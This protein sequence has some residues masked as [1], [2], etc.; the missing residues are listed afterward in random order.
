MS[1][2]SMKDLE[3]NYTHLCNNSIQKEGDNFEQIKNSSMWDLQSFKSFLSSHD[4]QA[5]WEDKILPQMK[6]I[7]KWALMCAQD[8]LE[9]RKFSCEVY[10]YDF[11]LD[12]D[13]NVWL[14]EV[15][16]SPDMSAS[17]QVT[18]RL[19]ERVMEDM[20]KVIVD[21][22]DFNW[23]RR[24]LEKEPACETGGWGL[25]HRGDQEVSFPI[26][27]FGCK[28]ALVGTEIPIHTVFVGKP[29]EYTLAGSSR[30]T[31][32]R[33]LREQQLELQLEAKKEPPKPKMRKKKSSTGSSRTPAVD[34]Q[35]STARGQEHRG[36]EE[37]KFGAL[38]GW[39]DEDFSSSAP[40][41]YLARFSRGL[42]LQ[43]Q[44]VET[45]PTAEEEEEEEEERAEV[46]KPRPG[47]ALKAAEK[48][49]RTEKIA[50]KLKPA[51]ASKRSTVPN[52]EVLPTR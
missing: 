32:A 22:K 8:M 21:A 40:A 46:R 34:P 7:S 52:K 33:K 49:R 41:G 18:E 24:R 26:S 51:N 11:I 38:G 30:D 13:L 42:S 5:A 45:S 2:F 12:Q 1:D 20:V 27:A 28:L 43:E 23:G 4:Q 31:R 39:G 9:N 17:T 29:P 37:E 47:W 36:E 16:A 10:G 14:L 25:V 48:L 6:R 3:D 19:T 35:G 15:N 50:E 44:E